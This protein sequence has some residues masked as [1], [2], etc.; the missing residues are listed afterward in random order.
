MLKIQYEIKLNDDGRPYIHLSEDYRDNPQDRFFALEITRYMLQMIFSN[1]KDSLDKNTV[2]T[3][4]TTINSLEKISD[5]VA[6]LLKE[7]ME[8]LGDSS[9]MFETQYHLTV[10]DV[11]E[12]DKLNYDGII[13]GT[14]ILKR[15]IGLKVLVENEMIIYELKNGIDNINWE[16][17]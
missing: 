4:S 13:T 17:I 5:E 9:F 3:L 7:E 14:K 8:F 16:K 12:R 15:Q 2:E 10:K 1:R 11:T 6:T